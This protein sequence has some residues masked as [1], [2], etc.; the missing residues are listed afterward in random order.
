MENRL[1]VNKPAKLA[2]GMRIGVIAPAGSVDESALAAGAEAIRNEGYD[3][4][5]APHVLQRKGY[6]AGDERQRAADL[7]C[8]FKR[9]DID[10]IFCARGGFGSVQ[11]L[12]YLSVQELRSRPKIF[13]GYSDITILLNWLMQDCG[14]VTFHG[15]MVAMEMAR[16]LSGRSRELFWRLL[17]GDATDWHM[18]MAGV[19]RPGKAEGELMGGCLTMLI[20]TLGTP[21][22]IETRGKL[23]FL[24]DVGERPYRIERMLTHLKM[25][26]KLKHLLGLIF[27]DFTS[28]EGQ[29]PRDLQQI[30]HEMFD[31]APYPVVTG[32]PAGHGQEHIA[33]PF[34]VKMM[35]DGDS[36]LLSLTE[37]PVA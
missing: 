27:G 23:L 33:L 4:E 6:L 2:S 25:A 37:S 35:L 9:T 13:V 30:I 36:G 1:T 15:P 3:V 22:E 20:S 11:M 14:M 18:Q 5:L 26:G 24:E 10:A 19:I 12:P 16:G 21:Y 34:G 28:C 17:R 8:F 32:M 7:L 29:G 31:D